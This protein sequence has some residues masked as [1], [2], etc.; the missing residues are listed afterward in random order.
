MKKWNWGAFFMPLPFG[1]ANHAYLTF[2]TLIPL[3]GWIFYF[4]SGF[5]G[6]EWAYNSGKFNSDEEFNAVMNSW[7]RAGIF[8]GI[9]TIASVVLT[10]A[11]IIFCF[12][13][14]GSMMGALA[15]TMETTL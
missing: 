4:V 7:N 3:V 1:F 6:S 8:V 2:L 12:C 11:W 13:L 5:C 10:I 15:S 9:L 14:A